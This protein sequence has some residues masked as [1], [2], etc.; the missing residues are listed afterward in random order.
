MVRRTHK[1][2]QHKRRSQKQKQRQRN[3]RGGGAQ[4]TTCANNL[5]ALV[6]GLFAPY[7]KA[8]EEK[9]VNTLKDFLNIFPNSKELMLNKILSIMED[10]CLHTQGSLFTITT[11]EDGIRTLSDTQGGKTVLNEKYGLPDEFGEQEMRFTHEGE[12]RIVGLFDVFHGPVI[13][14]LK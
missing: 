14:T 1:R 12:D 11:N 13:S 7:Q 9:G 3:Q 4:A 8:M 10:S 6:P 2:K 5:K